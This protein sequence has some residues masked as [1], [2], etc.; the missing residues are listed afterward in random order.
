VLA[1]I[2]AVRGAGEVEAIDLA[3]PAREATLDNARRNGVADIVRASTRSISDVDGEFDVVLANILAPV[4]VSMSD[5]L[6]RVVACDG[7]LVISGILADRH[8][9]VLEALHPMV[10]VSTRELEGWAAVEL[11]QLTG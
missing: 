8:D 5:D 3:D 4:L 9:H 1:V 10:V 11:R 6:R 7:T 2:A